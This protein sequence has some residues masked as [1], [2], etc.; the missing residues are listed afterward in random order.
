MEN[1][2]SNSVCVMYDD[3]ILIC[4]QLPICIAKRIFRNIKNTSEETDMIS[5]SHFIYSNKIYRV[6]RKEIS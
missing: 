3:V 2:F 4:L 5:F 6:D 1:A